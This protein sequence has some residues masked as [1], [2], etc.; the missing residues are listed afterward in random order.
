MC[1]L[2]TFTGLFCKRAL[3]NRGSFSKQT[4]QS[5]LTATHCNTLQHTATYCNTLQHTA[6][7]CNSQQHTATHSMLKEPQKNRAHSTKKPDNAWS[8]WKVGT[9]LGTRRQRTAL[10]IFIFFLVASTICFIAVPPK[11][12]LIALWSATNGRVSTFLYCQVVFCHLLRLLST[13]VLV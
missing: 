2:P 1:R 9:P 6:K 4:S 8:V 12:G 10:C 7:H 13:H 3:H 5:R 11:N